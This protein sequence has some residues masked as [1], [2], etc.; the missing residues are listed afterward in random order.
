MEGGNKGGREG[1][2]R[3][4]LGNRIAEG[5]GGGCFK[6]P[7]D[8]CIQRMSWTED[9]PRSQPLLRPALLSD[10]G[11]PQPGFRPGFHSPA[12]T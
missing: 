3:E 10:V 2:K 9:E 7:G 12:H 4:T 11:M 1:R 5:V 8:M 6:G